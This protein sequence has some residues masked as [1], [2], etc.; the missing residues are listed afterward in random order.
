MPICGTT[1]PPWANP[2]EEGLGLV[3]IGKHTLSMGV[4]VGGTV[5]LSLWW[6]T[7]LEEGLGLRLVVPL[8]LH[9]H[10]VRPSSEVALHI[11]SF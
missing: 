9:D 6:M 8:A 11:E 1:V 4:L 5:R 2:L 10:L 7:D 3:N